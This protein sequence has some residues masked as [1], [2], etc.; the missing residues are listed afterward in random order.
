[1]TARERL[2]QMML[3][4]RRFLVGAAAAAAGAVLAACGGSSTAPTATTGAAAA[5]KP[6]G[7]TTAGGS[8]PAAAGSTPSAATGSTPAAQTTG[9]ATP[10]FAPVA[11][12]GV[13]VKTTIQNPA[14]GK[15]QG[16]KP[17]EVILVWGTEQLTTHGTDPQT[18]VGTIAES[19]LRHMYEPLVKIERDAKT[20]SPPSPPHGSGWMTTRCSSRCGKCHVPQRRGVQCGFGEVQHHAPAR[21]EEQR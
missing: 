6:A 18:H 3:N 13:Q 4:R 14:Q 9:G 20:I 10:T 21:S 7:A 11:T 8:T 12:A 16:N 19:R 15:P 5:T 2:D 17:S 1:M